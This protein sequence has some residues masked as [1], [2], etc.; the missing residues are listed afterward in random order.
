MNSR[1]DALALRDILAAIRS[2]QE[3]RPDSRSRFEEF[4][5]YQSH[6]IRYL[7]QIGEA[8]NRLSPDLRNAYP[9]VP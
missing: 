4:E 7:I 9:Q 5:P 6:Y 2:I 1:G 3:Y 8:V